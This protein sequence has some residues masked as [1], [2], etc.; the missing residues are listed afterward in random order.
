[1]QEQGSTRNPVLWLVIGLPIASVVAGVGLVVIALRSGSTDAVIDTVQR[2][3]QIQVTELGPDER[4]RSLK[5]AAVLRVD[6]KAL[7]LLPVDGGFGEGTV[8]RDQTLTLT[9]SHPSESVQDRTLQLQPSELGWR[10]PIDLPLDHDWLLQ[11][12]PTDGAWR[13]R[14]RLHAG[15]LAAYMRPSLAGE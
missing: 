12:T 11:L 13:L 5:L 6:K 10:A 14:G 9:L 2:T 8:G 7:E 15:E 1:M 4:A 3:A